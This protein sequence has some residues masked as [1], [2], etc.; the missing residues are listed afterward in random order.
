MSLG[1]GLVEHRGFVWVTYESPANVS[2]RDCK[3]KGIDPAACVVRTRVCLNLVRDIAGWAKKHGV[4]L[5]GRETTYTPLQEGN[6]AVVTLDG[7]EYIRGVVV[8]R[9][10][11]KDT[12][13]PGVVMNAPRKPRGNAWDK[14][15]TYRLDRVVVELTE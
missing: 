1:K 12:T 14:F 5:V 9:K 7:H 6:D 3:A 13:P 10:V 11:L 4:E 15:R 8:S 2:K